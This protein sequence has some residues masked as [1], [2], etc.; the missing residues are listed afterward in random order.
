ML[1]MTH[2]TIPSRIENLTNLGTHFKIGNRCLIKVLVTF[3][4]HKYSPP[5][6]NRQTK[7]LLLLPSYN[8]LY[9]EPW[10]KYDFKMGHTSH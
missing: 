10:E 8:L 6:T 5:L 9:S 7:Y 1:V 2:T 4:C 3:N